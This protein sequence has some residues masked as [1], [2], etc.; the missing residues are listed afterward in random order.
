M[1]ARVLSLNA[2]RSLKLA[3]ES[4][5]EY[6]SKLLAMD[7]LALL[8]EMVAFQEHRSKSGALTPEL[9]VRGKLL[10]EQM[11]FAAETEALRLLTRSYRRH[12]ELELREF[13]RTG[14]L[15]TAPEDHRN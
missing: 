2:A 5:L 14:R 15:N 4:E 7:K 13:R 3:E 1:S 10:F 11:E 9:M 8:N 6:K 12:L